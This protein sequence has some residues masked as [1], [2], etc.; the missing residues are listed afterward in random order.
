MNGVSQ[1][2]QISAKKNKYRNILYNKTHIK[3]SIF[4]VISHIPTHKNIHQF[5]DMTGWLDAIT[6]NSLEMN[7]DNDRQ[8][9]RHQTDGVARVVDNGGQLD[10]RFKVAR[11]MVH[12]GQMTLVII[13]VI[14]PLAVQV[15]VAGCVLW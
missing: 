3:L 2:S 13:G 1:T 4:Y 15:T 9:Q 7:E 6:P 8:K 5:E 12:D 10:N 11:S 14:V